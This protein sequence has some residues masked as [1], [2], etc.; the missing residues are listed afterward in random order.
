[1][2]KTPKSNTMQKEYLKKAQDYLSQGRVADT[3][4]LLK[5]NVSNEDIRTQV[6]QLELRSNALSRKTNAG[7]IDPDDALLEENRISNAILM[8]I[9]NLA[10]GRTQVTTVPVRKKSTHLKWIIPS[11][12]AV[13]VVVLFFLYYPPGN[14]PGA[15]ISS[16]ETPA[17]YVPPKEQPVAPTPDPCANIRCENGGRCVNGSCDCPPGYTG[18]R[19]QTRVQ[20]SPSKLQ[21]YPSKVHNGVTWMTV[22]LKKSVSANDHK[23]VGGRYFY[24]PSVRHNLC[25]N[26]W[27][28][29]LAGEYFQLF[30]SGNSQQNLLKLNF[31]QTGR[32][33]GHQLTNHQQFTYLVNGGIVSFS[34]NQIAQSVTSGGR[35]LYPCRC[36][37][38]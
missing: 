15:V 35:M 19:C 12:L 20:T 33:D 11:V 17:P 37:K 5:E 18:D 32:V 16:G 4:S 8:I 9:T 6:L 28:L 22:D 36:V 13:V 2:S 34:R 24:K 21:T 27:R 10:R 26:G 25:P 1:V 23:V 14:D 7:T 38:E 31:T 29:P 3:I 30:N